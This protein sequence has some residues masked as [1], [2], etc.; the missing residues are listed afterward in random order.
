MK[1]WFLG[2]LLLFAAA[3]LLQWVKQFSL[4]LPIFILGGAFLAVASNFDK[5][6]ELPFHPD[7][8]RQDSIQ[9]SS[10]QSHPVQSTPAVSASPVKQTVNPQPSRSKETISFTIRKSHPPGE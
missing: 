7:H 8:D 3:E 4:P 6:T 2:F 10:V 1:V 5:L 9:S